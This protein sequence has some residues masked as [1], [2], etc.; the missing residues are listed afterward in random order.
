MA[1]T[2]VSDLLD[3]RDAPAP[4]TLADNPL[5]FLSSL[6]GPIAWRVPGRD[7]RRVRIVTTLLHGNELALHDWLRSGIQPAVD[8]LCVIANVEAAALHP[9]FTHRS[10]PRQRDLNRSFHGPFD[11]PSGRLA[12]SLL[13][14]IEA[15][16]AEALV[17]LHNNTGRN[18]ADA[19]QPP[20][21]GTLW[22]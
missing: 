1:A 17:D 6:G 9:V 12:R 10:V 5:T 18:P 2:S 20:T 8:A 13:D 3:V 15:S 16:Q 4:A 11:D 22:S 14:L 19:R 21:H 7:R